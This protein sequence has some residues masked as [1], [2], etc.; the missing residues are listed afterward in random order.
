MLYSYGTRVVYVRFFRYVRY[1]NYISISNPSSFY[2][3]TGD[4]I[5]S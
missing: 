4:I 3:T 1:I 5:R 2:T